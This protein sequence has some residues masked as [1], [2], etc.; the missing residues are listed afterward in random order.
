MESGGDSGTPPAPPGGTA[1]PTATAGAG[2]SPIAVSGG[3]DDTSDDVD[4]GSDGD[5]ETPPAPLDDAGPEDE[6]TPPS[7]STRSEAP[8]PV[9]HDKGPAA[10]ERAVEGAT[11]ADAAARN[12]G[13][14]D[15]EMESVSLATD[16]AEMGDGNAAAGDEPPPEPRPNIGLDHA[17]EK[18]GQQGRLN[19]MADH[20]ADEI[21][22]RVYNITASMVQPGGTMAHLLIDTSVGCSAVLPQ[23]IAALDGDAGL[24]AEVRS[25]DAVELLPFFVKAA[26]LDVMDGN[27]ATGGTSP[28]APLTH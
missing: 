22:R 21:M 24:M 19:T 12:D 13:A 26:L 5:S 28:N 10:P 3:G 17:F 16:A 11:P 23:A 7:A 6:A 2:T 25:V 1:A 27:T 14:D 8:F 20:A 9:D 4:M 15:I 18:A